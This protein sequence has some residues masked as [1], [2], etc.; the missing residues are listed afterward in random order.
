MRGE[1]S[2]AYWP[3]TAVNGADC[4]LGEPAGRLTA[5]GDLDAQ[6]AAGV[7]TQPRAG[8]AKTAPRAVVAT[9]RSWFRRAAA[10]VMEDRP[11][12]LLHDLHIVPGGEQERDRAVAKITQPHRRQADPPEC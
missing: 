4:C 10:M 12:G 8:S 2:G 9:I 6:P 1:S 7:V 3:R 11:T 5:D